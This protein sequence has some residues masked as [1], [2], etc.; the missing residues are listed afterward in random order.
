MSVKN[1]EQK[2]DT[3][4]DMLATVVTTLV[5]TPTASG[6]TTAP[7][8]TE[9]LKDIQMKISHALAILGLPECNGSDMDQVM[10]LLR[11]TRIMAIRGAQN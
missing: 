4:I 8:S 9:I 6:S 2:L 10:D 5:P 7:V 1:I 11:Q 3:I